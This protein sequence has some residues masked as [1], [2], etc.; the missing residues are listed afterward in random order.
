MSH[1]TF[2]RTLGFALILMLLALSLAEGDDSPALPGGYDVVR[3]M[4]GFYLAVRSGV[5]AVYGDEYD[6]GVP[7]ALLDG[8]GRVLHENLHYLNHHAPFRGWEEGSPL[9]PL[10]IGWKW[11]YIDRSG[12]LVIEPAYDEAE[13]FFNSTAVVKVDDRSGLIDLNGHYLYE[14]L[15]K[16]IQNGQHWTQTPG[17][18]LVA[19]Q[20]D[21]LWA[22]GNTQGQLLTDFLYDDMTVNWGT[23]DPICVERAGLVG[24][25]NPDGSELTPIQYQ[26]AQHRFSEGMASVH[27]SD[28]LWGYIDTTGAEVISP[29]FA[30]AEPFSAG[31]AAVED[32]ASTKWGYIDTTGAWV[33]EPKFWQ[34]GEFSPSGYAVVELKYDKSSVIDR[35][36]KVLMETEYNVAIS[37]DG[38]VTVNAGY[39]EDTAEF[40]DLSSGKAKPATI[41]TASVDLEDY[42]PFTGRKVAKLD[43]KPTLDH[44]IS[45]EYDLPHLDGATALFPVYAS[46]V[47]NLYPDETR[48][49]AWDGENNPL[50]TCT[51]TNVAYERLIDGEADIIFVAQP[52]D[53]EL[54]MA[55]EKGVAFDML[56]FGREA[57]VFVV[58]QKNPVEGLD[59]NEILWIY[60]GVVTEWE[61]VGVEGL[62]RIIPYQRPKNSGSQTA[63][64]ALMDGM[65]LMEAPQEYV[66]WDMVDI[67]ETVEYRNLPNALGYTFRF[68]C[69]EMMKSEVKLLSIDGVAPTVENIRNGTYP[70]TQTLYAIRLQSNTENPNVNALWEWLKGDQA[71]ELVEKSGYVA[72]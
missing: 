53:E 2:W 71:A 40:Y 38:I 7:W 47:E 30:G 68:F 42:M 46:F 19:L 50:I 64:E 28:G 72:N 4:D 41:L 27:A 18:D 22:L 59:L 6:P 1:S 69:T 51:K 56:P 26:H 55:E 67:L 49:E 5:L 9:A 65:P 15:Y 23:N 12:S 70:I 44:R 3:E 13:F 43:G 45:M 54:Q 35:T 39:G 24:F 66:A 29:Q 16:R 34:A 8:Q 48:Y 60:A 21:G 36:G 20:K 57:F 33:I 10:R 62:G 14:P 32:V 63:L 61:Q 58:N 37:D 52:S 31:L 11:G 25:I 17:N